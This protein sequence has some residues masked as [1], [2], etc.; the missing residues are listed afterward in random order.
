VVSAAD[1]LRSLISV[2]SNTENNFEVLAYGMAKPMSTE[3][4]HSRSPHDKEGT[5]ELK[6][7][8]SFKLLHF[9]K[10]RLFHYISR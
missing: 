6:A 4:H 8:T 5:G 3:T 10:W 1:P 2:L 7:E 9:K